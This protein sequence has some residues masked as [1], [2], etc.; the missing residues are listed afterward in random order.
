MEI[1]TNKELQKLL[2]QYPSDA[3][4][5]LV[6]DWETCN[7]DGLLTNIEEMQ[8]YNLGSQTE[9]YDVGLDFVDEHQIL[10]G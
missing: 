2:K 5:Y 1:M 8:D 6:K 9:V 10:I 4:V 7:E 3:K